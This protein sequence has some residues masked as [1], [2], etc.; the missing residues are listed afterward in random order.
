MHV[1]NIV[2]G[3][4][5]ISEEALFALDN[6]D[7]ENTE[8]EKT[9]WTNTRFLPALMKE[10]GMVSSISEVRRNKPSLCIELNSPDFLEVKWGKKKIWIA[11]GLED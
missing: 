9:I 3:K 2:V 6:E 7:W 4:P 5:L 8:K 11:V 1:E 10:I